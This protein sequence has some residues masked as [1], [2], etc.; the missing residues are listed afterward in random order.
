M[1]ST[2]IH[3]KHRKPEMSCA[4]VV[5]ITTILTPFARW[6]WINAQRLFHVKRLS[7]D[8]SALMANNTALETC[9]GL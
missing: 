5:F 9:Y 4:A 7:L 3:V 1:T 8:L 6:E 2:M